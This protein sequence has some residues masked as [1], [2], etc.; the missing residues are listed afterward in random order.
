MKDFL[1]GK[2]VEIVSSKNKS[3]VGLKGKIL[4]ETKETLV[5]DCGSEKKVLKNSC[6][7]KIDNQIV[8]GSEIQKKSFD[9]I[10]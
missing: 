2:Q 4:F 5:I 10:K 7:F 8:K 3:L 9:R 6:D 1:I